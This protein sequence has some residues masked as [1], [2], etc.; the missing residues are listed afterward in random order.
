[1]SLDNAPAILCIYKD[2]FLEDL[3]EDI[4]AIIFIALDELL[5]VPLSELQIHYRR[6]G[7][8]YVVPV[9]LVKLPDFD[10]VVVVRL[11]NSFLCILNFRAVLRSQRHILRMHSA[12]RNENSANYV[13]V[14]RVDANIAQHPHCRRVVRVTYQ[15]ILSFVARPGRDIVPSNP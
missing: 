9:S 2:S 5:D 13:D 1:M 14:G 15:A 7:I 4:F 8:V 11:L 10:W 6:R 3:D 12:V